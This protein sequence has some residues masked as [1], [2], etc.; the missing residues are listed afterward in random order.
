MRAHNQEEPSQPQDQQHTPAL[1]ET[2]ELSESSTHRLR[3]PMGGVV[4]ALGA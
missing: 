4:D 1:D 3:S 2:L